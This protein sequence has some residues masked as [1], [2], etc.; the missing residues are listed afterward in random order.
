MKFVKEDLNKN[1]S[2]FVFILTDGDIYAGDP[3]VPEKTVEEREQTAKLL[4][5]LKSE[6]VQT[7]AIRIG[8]ESKDSTIKDHVQKYYESTNLTDDYLQEA[9]GSFIKDIQESITIEAKTLEFSDAEYISEK[10]N[11]FFNYRSTYYYKALDATQKTDEF[12]NL[13]EQLI[14]KET[15]IVKA[16]DNLIP[17]ISSIQRDNSE[18]TEF[19]NTG[20]TFYFLARP[21]YSLTPKI[22]ATKAMLY[23]SGGQKLFDDILSKDTVFETIEQSS[24]YG[25]RIYIDY[26]IEVKNE[27]SVANITDSIWLISFMPDY[28]SLTNAP[29][30]Y[31]IKNDNVTEL[32]SSNV[33]T[34]EINSEN[35]KDKYL[36]IKSDYISDDVYNYLKETGHSAIIFNINLKDSG[37]ELSQESSIRVAYTTD[38]ILNNDDEMCYTG[39]VEILRYK[40]NNYRRLQYNEAGSIN[41]VA[42]NNLLSV[43]NLEKDNA[44]SNNMTLLTPTGANRSN[45]HIIYILIA[46]LI[47]LAILLIIIKK[48]K[49]KTI[50]KNVKL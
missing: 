21:T 6:G 30:F 42:G 38:R 3:W 5:E 4:E 20:P 15:R 40:N 49:K 39:F 9:I 41:A 8:P 32:N 37:F 19:Q 48:N 45:K 17:T 13:A 35:L 18:Q 27:S 11:S 43:E 28:V 25:S 10:S 36:K 7:C 16:S 23:N 26:E 50:D 31:G 44:S 1:K 33:Q 29:T 46:L 34:I 47:V 2:N 22:T 14:E 24:L 12:V